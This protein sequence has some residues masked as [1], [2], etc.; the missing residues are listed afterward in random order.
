MR[1]GFNFTLGDTY[2]M[3]QRMIAEG[4]I[5][6]CEI[7]IDNFF[8]VPPAELAQAFSCPIGFHIMFSRFFEDD[9]DTL[10]DFAQRMRGYIDALNPMYVSDHCAYFSHK[11][12]R[13]FHIGEFDYTRDYEVARKRA[14]FWQN[15]L[16]TKVLVENYPSIM[17]GG[18]DGPEFFQKLQRDTGAGVLFDASNAVC[19]NLNIGLPL[20]KWDPIVASTR[21]FHVA[22]YRLSMIEPYVQMDTHDVELSPETLSYLTSRKDLFDKHGATMTYERD[23]DIDYDLIVADLLRL[24]AIFPKEKQALANEPALATA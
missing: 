23:G 4:H 10:R 11:G 17:D 3:V 9:P 5:D 7:L 6:Y 20:E 24:R 14:E 2:E 22:G 13:L 18:H 16:G 8:C 21:H 1:L 12:R 19:A 15:E